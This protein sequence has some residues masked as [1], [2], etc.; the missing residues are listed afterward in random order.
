M[1]SFDS[2][3][4]SSVTRVSDK[5]QLAVF[6]LEPVLLDRIIT[7]DGEDRLFVPTEEMPVDC[8]GVIAG[9]RP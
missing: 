4:V 3:G 5:R 2:N 6:H 8:A 7:G 9:G 1:I